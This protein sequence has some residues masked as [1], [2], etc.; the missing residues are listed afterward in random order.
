[1]RNSPPVVAKMNYSILFAKYPEIGRVKTRLAR[2]LGNEKSV[3]FYRQILKDIIH[4]TFPTQSQYQNVLCYDPPER[5][6]E[7]K[8]SFPDFF[9]Y[10]PQ[11][12][13]NL[14]ERMVAAFQKSFQAGAKKTVIIGSDCPELKEAALNE[15]FQLLETKDLVLGPARDG[16]YYL[17]GTR[18]PFPLLF[19]EIP[20]ST[21]GVFQETLKRAKKN[22]LSVG[23]LSERSDIDTYEDYLREYAP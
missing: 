5:G 8:K 20:W 15:A 11:A 1:M 16:G 7:F 23:L 13:G 6:K 9:A 3:Q 10:W 19:Q 18:E 14:G 2:G 12:S 21:S 4:Q 17:I 22:H